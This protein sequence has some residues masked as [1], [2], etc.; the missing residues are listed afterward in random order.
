MDEEIYIEIEYHLFRVDS[1]DRFL[2]TQILL[3]ADHLSY[4]EPI[5][6]N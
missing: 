5:R 2:A 4:A 3:K 6:W 1:H